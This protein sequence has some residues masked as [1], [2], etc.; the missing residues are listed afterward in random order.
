[1]RSHMDRGATKNS[2]MNSLMTTSR[3]GEVQTPDDLAKLRSL[4]IW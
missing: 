4:G 1:M 3:E 2:G